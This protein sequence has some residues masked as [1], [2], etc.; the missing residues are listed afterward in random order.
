MSR[1]RLTSGTPR[2]LDGTRA[3]RGSQQAASGAVAGRGATV[4]ASGRLGLDLGPGFYFDERGRLN[5]LVDGVTLQVTPG[6]PSRLTLVLGDNSIQSTKKGIVA[7]PM[8][9][10]VMD[11]DGVPLSDV[12]ERLQ[13]NKQDRDEKGVAD[14][15]AGLDPGG[16]VPTAQ[17]PASLPPSGAAGGDLTGT[18]PNPTIGAGKVTLAQ[19]ANMATASVVY[20]KTAGA[21][22][23]EVN[24]L[25]TLK[26]DLGL[27][28]TNSGDQT[29]TLTGD[30]T[31]SGTGSFAA[32]IAN[33]AVTLAKLANMATASLFYRKTAGSGA[34]E[35]QTLATLK[36]D[37]GL[38]G[39]NTGD[40]VVRK[41]RIH[42][43]T[44]NYESWYLFGC[45]AGVGLST[46]AV[47][48]NRLY[49]RSF[50]AGVDTGITLD[51][52][53]IEVTTLLA[54][55]AR[56]GVY[57]WSN[58][59]PGSLVIDAGAVS[60]ATATAK[61]VTISQALTP[62]ERY[63][64]CVVF[65][66]APTVRALTVNQADPD[67]GYPSTLGAAMQTGFYAAFTYGTL[68]G[69]FP[70]GPPTMITGATFPAIWGR[71]SA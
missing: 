48:A 7:R 50:T 32:T 16:L 12:I 35:V 70:A 24:T 33:A 25:A 39:T 43:G 67:L 20:R 26:T 22:A 19:Q 11:L 14:G 34:P 9:S 13:L 53:A 30:V 68:P 5:L 6:S 57:S 44:S 56:M 45:T 62:G 61:P 21:G 64:A 15:Y 1:K 28:G 37:L 3:R 27:T 54:G 51:R 41:P 63:F 18:Y 4:D 52:M 23:P 47:T 10:E 40:Q 46:M 66:A 2:A 38:T 58:G 65:D 69:T 31:G 49:A 17:L 55:N 71:Y 60:T 36:T 29:I 8:T 59:Y 42:F